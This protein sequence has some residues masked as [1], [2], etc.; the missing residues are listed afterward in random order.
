[1]K[2]GLQSPFVDIFL[3]VELMIHQFKIL[4]MHM[5]LDVNSGACTYLMMA[6]NVYCH[7][8]MKKRDSR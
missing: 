5:V 8:L 6:S 2:L 1:M 3:G 7:V 4:D